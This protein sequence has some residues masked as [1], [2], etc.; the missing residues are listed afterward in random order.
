MVAAFADELVL[1]YRKPAGAPLS[2]GGHKTK[3]P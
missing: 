2:S 1:E 3:E